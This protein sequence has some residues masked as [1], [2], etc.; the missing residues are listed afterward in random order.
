MLH[1]ERTYVERRTYRAPVY[2]RVHLI[3]QVVSPGREGVLGL[4]VSFTET[5]TKCVGDL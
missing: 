1:F 2:I 3:L 4:S 5:N